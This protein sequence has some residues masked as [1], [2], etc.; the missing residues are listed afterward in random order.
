MKT[1]FTNVLVIGGGIAAMKAAL[2]AREKNED[3]LIIS[4][5]NT[6][7]SGCSLIS[8]GILNGPF[9]EEDSA[10]LYYI[11]IIKGSADVADKDLANVMANNAKESVLSLQKFG[12]KFITRDGSLSLDLSGGNSVAR[13]VK[14]DPPGPG[15]GKAI[16]I[17]LYEKLKTTDIRA[18]DGYSV[19]KIL[20]EGN[21]AVSAIA[22]N[23]NDF[24]QINFKSAV[25][26]T[27]GGGR[28]YRNSTNPKGISGD[29]IFLG[30]D[31][32]AKL[33]DMEYVQFFP[34]VALTSY[35]VLPFI[36]T[37]GA[38]LINKDGERFI[39]RYDPILM[40]K[41][42]R[43]KMSQA[44]FTED[45]EGRGVDGGVFIS[46]KNMPDDILKEKYGKE[47]EFFKSKNID[48][49]NDPL[50]VKPACHFFMGGIKI[51]DTCKTNIDGLYACG[52]CAGGTHGANRLAGNAL[53]E[54]LVFGEIAGK[55]ATRYANENEHV[56]TEAND[57]IESLP[58]VDGKTS[59]ANELD[60]L[61]ELAWSY[62]GI[63]R[64][65]D[66][67]NLALT[68]IYD[69]E[70]NLSKWTYKD[71]DEFFAIRNSLQ[72]LKAIAISAL[73]RKESRGAH[74]RSDYPSS[75]EEW[76]K[77]ILI[78]GNFEISYLSR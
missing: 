57:F 70:K 72:I 44:I 10:E 8:E 48:L 63:I 11:D 55:N 21:R 3:V 31:A 15:C 52:E 39:E 43:D 65:E 62:L 45:Q 74:Y 9:S 28:L 26:A 33:I 12:V 49:K 78:D 73:V 47:V 30:I 67:L 42:T 66:G 60:D 29:G 37:D 1:L 64:N 16:P 68:R 41:T 20:T 46:C 40:E 71:F 18:I 2:S 25:L 58:K 38:I 22:H 35:L 59:H 27:G 54:A 50:L 61:K 14:I 77:A 34:T 53:V 19:V 23:G 32:N 4:K 13:T 24:I 36:F 56:Q 7:R 17:K 76:K 75:K 5:G 6:G 69:M 51:D